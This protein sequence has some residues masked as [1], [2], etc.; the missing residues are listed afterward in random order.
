[1]EGDGGVGGFYR[2]GGGVAADAPRQ[3]W[4]AAPGAPRGGNGRGLPAMTTRT[5]L[6]RVL[7]S[8]IYRVTAH[9]SSRLNQ[10]A[11]PGLTFAANFPPCLQNPTIPPPSTPIVF[12]ADQASPPGALSLAD[13]L[14][15]TGTI[16]EL[17]SFLFTFIYSPPYA[18]FIPVA[19]IGEDL[20][21]SA[22]DG[23][24]ETCNQALIRYR[25]DLQNFIG[26]YAAA[27]HVPGVPAQI[28][29]WEL[30]IET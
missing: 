22:P 6:K 26:L 17:T 9:G 29:Q 1:P 2:G 4:M 18:P 23:I 24:G 20:S 25:T 7:T 8:L 10:A 15:H 14:P 5:A 12:K 21:F 27:S 11:N 16:G 19:G 30:S 13:Y 28:H 3:Q